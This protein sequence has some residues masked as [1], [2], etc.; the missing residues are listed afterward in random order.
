LSGP[1]QLVEVDADRVLALPSSALGQQQ[2]LNTENYR[3][4]PYVDS[5]GDGEAV[6]YYTAQNQ[7]NGEF[8]W[9]V[10]PEQIDS[11]IANESKMMNVAA[12]SRAFGG[13]SGRNIYIQRMQRDLIRKDL[14]GVATNF[15]ESWRSAATDPIYYLEAS[16]SVVAG[17]ALLRS[18]TVIEGAAGRSA[19][20]VSAP[21]R[22][23]KS[24]SGNPRSSNDFAGFADSEAAGFHSPFRRLTLTND[25]DPAAEDFARRF[26]GQS[27]VKIEGF[28]DR[29][30]DMVSDT[31]VGQTFGPKVVGEK[32]AFELSGKN[33][34]SQK[35]R[36][37]IRATLEAAHI[38]QRKA[39]FEFR[40]GAPASEVK[41][42]IRRNGE[43]VGVRF[44]IH[45]SE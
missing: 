32:P 27:S 21:T 7:T 45:T 19:L 35:R 39:L 12:Y 42:F 31:Y 9:V 43:R 11:F 28:G 18:G 2:H 38:T 36:L 25:I 23:V 26:N 3:F 4:V 40:G 14:A 1:S 22:Q 8:D 5:S 30:F 24:S 10:P 16:S 37:Q 17:S 15:G 6:R 34:M 41:D 33:F 44:E 29:E 13:A 20:R